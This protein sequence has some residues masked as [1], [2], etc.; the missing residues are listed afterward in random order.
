MERDGR[1]TG[2]VE[3]VTDVF[4]QTKVL[5][6]RDRKGQGGVELDRAREKDTTTTNNNNNIGIG[7]EEKEDKEKAYS[8]HLDDDVDEDERVLR[9]FDL[10][11]KYGPCTGM[12][13]MER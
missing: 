9:S 11:S 8:L 3:K 4:Q 7:V 13:R 6:N 1:G 12:S 10:T 2:K 5:Q